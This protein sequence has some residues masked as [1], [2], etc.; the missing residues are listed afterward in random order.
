MECKTNDPVVV[1][2]VVDGTLTSEIQVVNATEIIEQPVFSSWCRDVCF[3]LDENR[4]RI[5]RVDDSTSKE[6]RD[7]RRAIARLS[8]FGII[9]MVM[10]GSL[11]L[12]LLCR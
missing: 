10:M 3:R 12:Y 4:E 6:I 1:K 7:L 11:I 8:K 9:A 5:K 2:Y